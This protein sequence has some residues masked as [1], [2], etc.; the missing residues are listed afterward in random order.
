MINLTNEII[1][2]DVKN[3]KKEFIKSALNV[4]DFLLNHYNIEENKIN[5][6]EDPKYSFIYHVNKE[7]LNNIKIDKKFIKELLFFV[8]DKNSENIFVKHGLY[9]SNLILERPYLMFA[10]KLV[11]LDLWKN[12]IIILPLNFNLNSNI[13]K[14][15]DLNIFDNEL[16]SN[17]KL[18]FKENEDRYSKDFKNN[19]IKQISKVIRTTDYSTFEDICL[20]EINDLHIEIQK[21][22]RNEGDLQIGKSRYYIEA[23]L[24]QVS[25]NT[26]LENYDT[27]KYKGWLSGYFRRYKRLNYLEYLSAEEELKEYRR[28]YNIQQTIE[29]AAKRRKAKAN[30]KPKNKI[31]KSFVSKKV[32]NTKK[33]DKKE[34]IILELSIEDIFFKI[35][36]SQKYSWKE[37][38]PYYEE[39]K[40]GDISE[41]S[42]YWREIF[43]A[44]LNHRKRNGYESQKTNIVSFNFLMNYIFFY[45]KY[46]NQNNKNKI[47]IPIKPKDLKRTLFINNTAISSEL[48][49]RP[50]TICE[51]LEYRFDSPTSK[52]IYVRNIENLFNFIIDFYSE[53]SEYWEEGLSNPIRKSDYYKE[54]KHK[55]TN[56]VI[57]PKNIYGKLK[58]YLYSIE[59][60]GEYLQEKSLNNEIDFDLAKT[61]TLNTS[62][63]GFIPFFYNKG[64]TYPI[65]EVSNTFLYKRRTF[66]INKLKNLKSKNIIEQKIVSNTI[67]RALI[68][69]LNTGLRAAQVSWIDRTN[70]DLNNPKELRAYYKL[71]VNTDK[72]KNNEWS[73]YIAHNVYESL[74]KETH[75]QNAMRE[76][77]INI[78]CNYQGREY[79]R[80]EDII[81][82]FKSDSRKG[83]P[84]SFTDYWADIL[85][86][87]QNTLN[88][89]ENESY[90]LITITKP[91]NPQIEINP[92][93]NQYSPLNIKAIHTPHSMRATFC[94]HMA[95]YLGRSE[96]AALVGHASDLITSEVYIKPEDS[97]LEEKI[98]NAVNIL[99]QGVNADYFDKES[100][101]HIK[102][103]QKGSALQKAFSENRDETIE[104]FNITSISMNINK[105]SEKQSEKAIKLL[106]D[107][108]MDQVI[109]ETTHIC[110]VGGMCPQ[111]VMGVIG[112]KRRCGLC[113]LALKCIDNINPIYAKQRDLMREIKEGK[114]KLD[115]AIKNNESSITI[116]DIEN[117]VNLDIRELVSWKF[118]ADI[119]SE[120][121][122]SIKDNE[123]LD[124]KYYVEMPEMVKQH[125]QKVSVSNEKEYLLTRIAD[126]NAY[127]KLS[128]SENKYQAEMLKRSIV[129]NL[130]LIEYEDYIVS[131][132]EKIEVFC[133]M[134]KNML[135]TNG[136]GLKEL[137]DYDCMKSIEE[138]KEQKK[139]LFKDIK[140][141]K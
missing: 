35:Q 58:K 105:D 123:N 65:Y 107:A 69:M 89:T 42:K 16:L 96:I 44:Y 41:E 78:P 118:S 36:S 4:K 108:R 13:V 126:S 86:C 102:P 5:I 82:L 76:D 92:E 64:K 45:L 68:L 93:G 3:I 48:D 140:L 28:S 15:N 11:L 138:K 132:D 141:L 137:V 114:E 27:N 120:H 94:T 131:E 38:V 72:T 60:F 83:L 63:L 115:L 51:L 9:N 110:P 85:W 21:A 59:C 46:W 127:S 54:F 52:N 79:S 99:D 106:K 66:D 77:F 10:F 91:S 33:Q 22:N 6:S 84:V 23:F 37:K 112:E 30:S 43:S 73:T 25:E 55:K 136:I 61:K 116:E 49:E 113:P 2:K 56:K 128:N 109:F 104:L 119:L 133:A 95:E 81:C 71:N 122:E 67:V 34:N 130:N 53:E 39:Y 101:A 134:I 87:F 50:F 14:A 7:K 19:Y 47:N 75:F 129:K 100:K 74:K 32:N 57:I 117:K 31:K 17:I 97:V 40:I 90:E 135:D 111:E 125:L 62:K 103:N 8:N 1:I 20:S 29:R 26:E 24:I 12:K 121:Y 18:K 98:K 139:L 70:W 88:K 80:F 124:K